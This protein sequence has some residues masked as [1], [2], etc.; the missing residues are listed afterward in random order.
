MSK[1]KWPR[2]LVTGILEKDLPDKYLNMDGVFDTSSYSD[3]DL[4]GD[5]NIAAA[6]GLRPDKFQ[7]MISSPGSHF[8]A[9]QINAENR[10]VI[11]DIAHAGRVIGHITHTDSAQAG[12]ESYRDAARER[13]V[14]GK[15]P[16][17]VSGGSA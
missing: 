6:L 17:D 4:L 7:E 1:G 8:H 14:S 5:R 3:S 11:G 15:K 12:M 10:T 2:E 16:T 9:H 13:M